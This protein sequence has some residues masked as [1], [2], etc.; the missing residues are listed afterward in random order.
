MLADLASDNF[1]VSNEVFYQNY[2]RDVELMVFL[3]FSL[4]PSGT[5]GCSPSFFLARAADPRAV[6][7]QR[8]ARRQRHPHLLFEWCARAQRQLGGAGLDCC[9]PRSHV[10][11]SKGEERRAM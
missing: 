1:D 11:Q 4:S 9:H 6:E 8:V 5:L 10:E 2:N 7:V 3:F